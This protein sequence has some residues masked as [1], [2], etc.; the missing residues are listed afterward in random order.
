MSE[1]FDNIEVLHKMFPYLKKCDVVWMELLEDG[2]VNLFG[3]DQNNFV[4]TYSDER[5]WPKI[6]YS[7][8]VKKSPHLKSLETDERPDEVEESPIHTYKSLLRDL[9]INKILE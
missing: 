2:G 1:A 4:E 6:K 3:Y 7:D 8:Y 5:I 9:K